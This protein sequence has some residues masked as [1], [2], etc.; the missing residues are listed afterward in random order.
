MRIG[1]ASRAGAD[2]AGGCGGCVAQTSV[3]DGDGD[4]GEGIC[5]RPRRNAWW[6]GKRA[7]GAGEDVD[8]E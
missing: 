2:K 6:W 3:C 4:V 5:L 1:R 8:A 7:W